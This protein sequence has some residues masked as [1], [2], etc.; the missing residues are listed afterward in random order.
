VVLSADITKIPP[1]QLL[2][3]KVLQTFVGGRLVYG[4]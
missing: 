3:T 1:Q 4:K 2:T